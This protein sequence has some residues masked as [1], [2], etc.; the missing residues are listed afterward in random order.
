MFL[1][2]CLFYKFKTP[3]TRAGGLLS[4]VRV[5]G[6]EKERKHEKRGG[7]SVEDGFM[8]TGN[9]KINLNKF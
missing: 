5:F 3:K 9:S 7:S 8:I 1:D 6:L 2:I 4:A